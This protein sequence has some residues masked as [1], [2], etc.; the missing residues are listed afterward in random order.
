MEKRQLLRLVI[1]S[2]LVIIV[3]IIT[4]KYSPSET[5]VPLPSPVSDSGNLTTSKI[6]SLRCRACWYSL[7]V[8]P[9]QPSTLRL[10]L[11]LLN[12]GFG[13]KSDLR[14]R[15]G[16]Q[17]LRRFSAAGR[18]PDAGHSGKSAFSRRRRRVGLAIERRGDARHACD[19]GHSLL[20]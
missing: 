12:D 15:D 3:S 11:V 10:V 1:P 14:C 2:V 6:D 9:P 18:N 7:P 19:A 17:P 13:T 4:M 5:L 8:S 16:I 20:C